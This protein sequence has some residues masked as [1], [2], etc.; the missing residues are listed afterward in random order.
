MTFLKAEDVITGKQ[1]RA[2]ATINSQ[3]E[4]LFYAK[5]IEAKIEKNKTDVPILGKMN[6]GKKSTGWSGSG[7]LT[8]YYVTSLFRS[9]M[10]KYIKTGKDFYFDLQITNEDTTSSIG[11][12]TTVLKNCNLDS[13]I[14]ASFDASS[15]DAMEEE[16]PFTFEDADILDKF[17]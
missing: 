11:K 10:L 9:L 6:V 15:D 13:V 16:L 1:A 4:E 3:V 12:Q 17:K 8:V 14:I 5:S 2:F 7:T